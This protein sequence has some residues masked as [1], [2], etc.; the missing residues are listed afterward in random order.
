MIRV[1]AIIAFLLGLHAAKML[2]AHDLQQERE[3]GLANQ[4]QQ[5][6]ILQSFF[7]LSR[8]FKVVYW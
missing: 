5:G 3:D 1:S 4:H 6:A 8:P 7:I 2:F